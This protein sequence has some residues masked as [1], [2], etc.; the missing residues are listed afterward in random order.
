MGLFG[1]QSKVDDEMETVEAALP[2]QYDE[3]PELPSPLCTTSRE[4]WTA[5]SI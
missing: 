2:E 3:V 1:R 5:R 4:P